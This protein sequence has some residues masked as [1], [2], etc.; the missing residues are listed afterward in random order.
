VLIDAVPLLPGF[1]WHPAARLWRTPLAGEL[2]MGFTFKWTWRRAGIPA[3]LVDRAWPRFDHGT[4]RAILKLYRASPSHVL[5]AA[6]ERLGEI[7]APALIVWGAGDP[8]VSASFAHAYAERLGGE[9]RVELVEDG[10]H[11]PWLDRPEIV[12]LVAEQLLQPRP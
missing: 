12:D 3:E 7:S 2:A 8:Y 10:G 11:W 6:G 5:E 1:R 4:Q 9:S